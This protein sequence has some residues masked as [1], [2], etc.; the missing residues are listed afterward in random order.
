MRACQYQGCLPCWALPDPSCFGRLD[1]WRFEVLS[2]PNAA[3]SMRHHEEQRRRFEEQAQDL[4]EREHACTRCPDSGFVCECGFSARRLSRWINHTC[5]DS[6]F[7]FTQTW[8]LVWLLGVRKDARLIDCLSLCVR[9]F[10]ILRRLRLKR[11]THLMSLGHLSLLLSPHHQCFSICVEVYKTSMRCS[12]FMERPTANNGP[13]GQ[14]G[15][16]SK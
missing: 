10:L 5:K 16:P 12:P 4:I 3:R 14:Q 9:S 15:L 7:S 8:C 11:Q 1:G 6:F 2:G 13:A